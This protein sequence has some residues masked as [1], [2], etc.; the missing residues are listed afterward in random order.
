M[1]CAEGMP[2]VKTKS[3]LIDEDSAMRD[4]A[5]MSLENTHM[6]MPGIN[7]GPVIHAL[8]RVNPNARS[9]RISGTVDRWTEPKDSL[10]AVSLLEKLFTPTQLL[11][12][13]KSLLARE[14]AMNGR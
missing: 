13:L 8:R 2:L 1:K 12:T 3:F 4:F 6:D 7:G 9:V 10:T 5:R 11:Q 14:Q